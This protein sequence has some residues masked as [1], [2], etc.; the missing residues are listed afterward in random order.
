M[1][2]TN[3]GFVTD[4]WTDGRKIIEGRLQTEY[5]ENR[6]KTK[7]KILQSFEKSLKIFEDPKILG[8]IVNQMCNS[9]SNYHEK[10]I[11]LYWLQIKLWTSKSFHNFHPEN[12][13]GGHL[14]M[15]CFVLSYYYNHIISAST[16]PKFKCKG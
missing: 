5:L 12:L 13:K 10:K 9:K 2:Q 1:G 14:K 16:W 3:T 4:W 8:G 15:S 6:L 7:M 11:W